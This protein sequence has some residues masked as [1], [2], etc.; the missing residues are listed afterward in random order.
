MGGRKSYSSQ[1]I[2]GSN[3]LEIRQDFQNLESDFKR[4]DTSKAINQLLTLAIHSDQTLQTISVSLKLIKL[5]YEIYRLTEE[6]YERTGDFDTAL[7]NAV[8]TVIKQKMRNKKQIVIE[9][10]VKFCWSEV[11]EKYNISSPATEVDEIVI[12]SVTEALLESIG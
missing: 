8:L 11:K 5:A 9:E 1:N 6:E 4:Q 2:V 3:R 7:T 12:Y 10:A